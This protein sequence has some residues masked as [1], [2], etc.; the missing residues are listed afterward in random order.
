MQRP[1]ELAYDRFQHHVCWI[2]QARLLELAKTN[3]RFELNRQT[4]RIS[5]QTEVLTEVA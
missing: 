5:V 1:P 3:F 4:V 2:C